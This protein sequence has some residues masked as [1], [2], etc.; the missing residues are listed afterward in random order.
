LIARAKVKLDTPTCPIEEMQQI[1]EEITQAVA[2]DENGES[3]WS[4]GQEN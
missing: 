4:V 1:F 3:Q 2:A